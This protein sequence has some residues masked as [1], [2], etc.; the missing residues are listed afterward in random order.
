[1]LVAYNVP[2][3]R[4]SIPSIRNSFSNTKLVLH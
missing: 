1:V 4:S 3:S 2:R